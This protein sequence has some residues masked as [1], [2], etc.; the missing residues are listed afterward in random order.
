[1]RRNTASIRGAIVAL[2]T[3]FSL[4]LPWARAGAGQAGRCSMSPTTPTRRLYR[5]VD[6]A[7]IKE[8]QARVKGARK[9]RGQRFQRLSRY[10]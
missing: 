8:Y 2:A 6:E 4:G 10:G 1:M 5:A 9:R 7:F 3:V